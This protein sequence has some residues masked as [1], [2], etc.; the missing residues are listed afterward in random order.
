MK[1]IQKFMTANRCFTAPRELNPK[2]V[3]LHSPGVAQSDSD[4]LFK[5]MNSQD[6]SVSVHA[7]VEADMVVQTLPWNYRAWHVGSGKN[8]SYNELAIGVEVC[9]P[10]GHTYPSG[11][12]MVGYDVKANT[13]YFNKVYKNAVELTAMLCKEYNLNPLKDIVC[14]SEVYSLGYGSNHA[15]VMHW[16][17]KH[18]KSMDT[19]REDVKSE[20]E[21]VPIKTINKKS[22]AQDIRWMQE[23]LNKVNRNYVI[24]VTGVFDS[25]TRVSV[26]MFAVGMGWNW[27]TASGFSVGLASIKILNG[28]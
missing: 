6:V 25:K 22:S 5:N 21:Y 20:M 24:P 13:D 27:D 9:E 10:K 28:K 26:L 3:V 11:G 23:K 12:T 7:F 19:F 17:P 15:D 1:L 2:K 4:I 14:H 16:F 18:G 8:G